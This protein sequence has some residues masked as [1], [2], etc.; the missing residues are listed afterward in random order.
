MSVD[1]IH[2][3]GASGSGTTTLGKALEQKYNYKWIDTDDYFWLP[4]EPPFTTKRPVEERIPLMKESIEQN[5]QCVISGSLCGWGDVFIPKFD[6]VIF[7]YTSANIRKERL[8]NREYQ[9]FGE[10]IHKG[11]DMYETHINLIN[12]AMAYD[13]GDIN[14]RSAKK[15]EDWLKLLTCPMVRLNGENDISHNL[16]QLH[17]YL[18]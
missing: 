7:I 9:I 17:K 5:P 4:T 2:I 6:L 8:L 15:H 14:M 18:A 11:G 3:L 13:T 16:N 10:R 1:V 12:W